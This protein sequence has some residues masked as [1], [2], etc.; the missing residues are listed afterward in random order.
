[1]PT[2]N[3]FTLILVPPAGATL[4]DAACEVFVGGTQT[5]AYI[6]SDAALTTQITNPISITSN[7]TITFYAPWGGEPVTGLVA[8]QTVTIEAIGSTNFTLIGAPSNTVGVTFQCTGAGTGTGTVVVQYDL[9]IAGGNIANGQTIQNIWNLVSPIWYLEQSLWNQDTALWTD[10]GAEYAAI[11]VKTVQNVGQMYTGYDLVRA[12]MRL[13]QVAS[14]DTDLTASELKDGIEALNRMIDSWSVDELTLY[15]VVREQ[16]TLQPNQTFFEIGLGAEFN[17]SRPTRIIDAYFTLYNAGLPVDYPMAI[18]QYDDYNAIAL[19]TLSTNF[20]QY[21]YYEPSFPIGKVYIY[22][23]AQQSNI[24]LTLTSWK[25]LDMIADPTA[26]VQLP[27]GYWE[28]IVFGLAVRIAME[29]QFQLRPDTIQMAERSLMRL[30]RMNQRTPSLRTD[31]ALRGD[32]N[33]RYNIYSNSFG[34]GLY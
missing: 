23:L 7:N 16:F 29:Y 3:Q 26:Y 28:A 6:Y 21:L 13:I 19:K 9:L 22:P 33:L 11:G 17:T 30:K 12:A 20:P 34:P 27:P 31:I 5:P 14:V 15:K 1:M 2:A 18:V 8:G 24:G 4:G 25:P 10:T 32:K